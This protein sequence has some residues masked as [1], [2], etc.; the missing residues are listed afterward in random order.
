MRIAFLGD[1]ITEGCG[2]SA[3]EFFYV[4]QVGKTLNAKVLNYGVGGTRIARQKEVSEIGS[5]FSILKTIAGG[6]HKLGK[7]AAAME[8]PQTK[9]T[10]YLKILMLLQTAY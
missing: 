7:I 1:S 10:N 6:N 3:E 5:Y 8:V 2:A 4:N 9:L